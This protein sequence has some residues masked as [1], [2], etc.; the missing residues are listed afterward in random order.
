MGFL[1]DKLRANSLL[2]A[3]ALAAIAGCRSSLSL[4]APLRFGAADR[5]Q[6]G[7]TKQR[8]GAVADS[9]SLP[10]ELLWWESTSG[11]AGGAEMLAGD[12]VVIVSSIVGGLDIYDALTGDERGDLSIKAPI[13]G[14]PAI[15]DS[16]LVIPLSIGDPSLLCINLSTRAVA[17]QKSIG[18]MDAS[19]LSA[20]DRVIAATLDGGV[21]CIRVRDSLE[22][23]AAKLPGSVDAGPAGN[24][25][26]VFVACDN[27]DVY[28]LSIRDGSIMWR[29]P[30]GSPFRAG[31]LV[32]GPFV[33]VGTRSGR[34]YCLDANTGGTKWKADVGASISARPATDGERL[35]VP[36]GDGSLRAFSIA[37][38]AE[39]WRHETGS[40][41]EFS[42][43]SAANAVF[44]AS[45]DGKLRAVD[46]GSGALVWE[47]QADSP[48]RCAP[49]AYEGTIF[50]CT[51]RRDIL[52][53]G[54]RR[55]P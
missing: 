14:T 47:Y 21:H 16:F 12:G 35:F 29:V 42:P 48:L 3:L 8:E 26:L 15:L 37:G 41:L 46:P 44:V 25:S 1:M 50:I 53:F 49:A 17:W 28:G 9:F 7:V 5:T 30:T 51:D 24:D 22:L 33:V 38:G 4:D 54:K 40:I 6:E 18:P 34:I 20:G 23:W 32:A 13:H 45:L 2:F 39:L 52:A 55:T 11:V 31:P 36:L 43:L 10:L 27:G 19:L